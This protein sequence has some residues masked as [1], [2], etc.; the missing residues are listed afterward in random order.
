[1]R[2]KVRRIVIYISLFLFPLILNYLSPYVS[3]RAAYEGIVAGS[4]LFFALLFLSGIFLGRAWCAWGCPVAAIGELFTG[5]YAITMEVAA[6]LLL[7][8]LVGAIILVREDK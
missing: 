7:V 8:A 1:M 2:Q 4:A 5:K 3:Q 6:I